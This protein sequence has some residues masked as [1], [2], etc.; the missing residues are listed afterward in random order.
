[1]KEFPGEFADL[2]TPYGLRILNG[3]VE[4]ACSLFNGAGNYFA[5]FERVIDRKKADLCL[6]SLDQRL[7][8]FLALER[9]AIPPDSITGMKS[10]YS[11]S[12]SKVMRM[13]TA[14][15]LKKTARSYKAAESIGLLRM[16]RSESLARF[17]EVITGYRL[18]RDWDVQATCYEHGDYVGPHNDHH[19][20]SEWLRRGFIDLH[21]MFAND[22]VAHQYLVY[23]QNGHL[24]KLVDVNKQGAVSIYKLPFWH[25]T[26]PLVGKRTREKEA[27][28]WLLL[29]SFVIVDDQ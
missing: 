10:N 12:L 16:M 3:K 21:I 17:A 6:Q 14:F 22:A 26:T 9:H 23:E 27:R 1:V 5:S 7:Y 28:R 18:H 13:K 20:E 8:E 2:L 19:P 4:T 24:S 25:Y 11:E 15:F 29:G